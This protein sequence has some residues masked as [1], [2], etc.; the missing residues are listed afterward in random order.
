MTVEGKV[1]KLALTLEAHS[2]R[3]QASQS[4]LD[5]GLWDASW[6]V[7]ASRLPKMADVF[8]DHA[9]RSP[10]RGAAAATLRA[11]ASKRMMSWA[12]GHDYKK[13]LFNCFS[14]GMY[15]PWWV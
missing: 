1:P 5:A 8:I 10:Q 14:L 4:I 9:R 15:F 11:L 3:I 7:P 13:N 6:H 2:A 12:L